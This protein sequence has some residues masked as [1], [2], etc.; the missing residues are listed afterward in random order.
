MYVMKLVSSAV[1]ILIMFPSDGKIIIYYQLTYYDPKGLTCSDH[2]WPIVE[3]NFSMPSFVGVGKD[4]SFLGTFSGSS[5]LTLKEDISELCT[6][7]YEKYIV[8]PQPFASPTPLTRYPWVRVPIHQ[9][10]FLFPHPRIVGNP[11]KATINLSGL[12]LDLPISYLSKLNP[13]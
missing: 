11:M 6:I 10:K 5:P 8:Q 13:L 7:T 1:I 9:V 4:A 2:D 12:N 3:G